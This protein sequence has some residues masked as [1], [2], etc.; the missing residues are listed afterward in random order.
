MTHT[1]LD[2]YYQFSRPEVRH[3]VPLRARKVLDV[4][5]AAGA[6]GA[7]LKAERDW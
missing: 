1:Q 2:P 5:C 7:A 6:M 4:G 3:L